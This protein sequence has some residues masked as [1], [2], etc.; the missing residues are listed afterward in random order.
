MNVYIAATRQN[1]GKT[2]VSLGLLSALGKVVKR[3]GYMKPV[4]QQYNI[5]NGKKIDKDAVLMKKIFGF[6]SNLSDM[7]PIAIPAGFTENYILR[8]NRT[9]LINKIKR[10]YGNLLRT[11]N[12][13]LIEGTG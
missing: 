5:I 12:F 11:S 10:A 13:V 1:D 4:G 2:I 8:G 7:S 9:T 6:K 3:I